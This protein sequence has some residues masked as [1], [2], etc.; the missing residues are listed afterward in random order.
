VHGALETELE[1][2]LGEVLDPLR[3]VP[4][5]LEIINKSLFELI[6]AD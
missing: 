3:K 6:H 4:G 1:E 5:A 2:E